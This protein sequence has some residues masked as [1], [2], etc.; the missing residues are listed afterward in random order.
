MFIQ[1]E[2]LYAAHGYTEYYIFSVRYMVTSIGNLNTKP[3]NE[4]CVTFRIVELLKQ[5]KIL[6][7]VIS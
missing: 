4:F 2:N 1:K 5:K 3:N 7:N 6:D